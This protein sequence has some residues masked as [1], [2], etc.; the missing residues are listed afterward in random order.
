MCRAAT[1]SGQGLG[2]GDHV[3]SILA[4]SLSR[5]PELEALSI[6]SNRLRPPAI[7]DI[8][9]VGPGTMTV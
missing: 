7:V 6:A 3:A 8:F 4:E 9:Q 1:S 2:L 5:F